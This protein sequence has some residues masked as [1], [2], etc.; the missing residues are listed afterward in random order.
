[1]STRPP[2]PP[3]CRRSSSGRA[4]WRSRAPRSSRCSIRPT[5]TCRSTCRS[6]RSTASASGGASRSSSTATP[7]AASRARSASSPIRRTSRPR[8]SR[9]GATAWARSTAPRCACWRTWSISSRARKA[10]CTA[11]HD[12]TARPREALRHPARARRHRSRARA[13]RDRG[14]RRARRRREDDALARAGRAPRGRGRRGDRPRP[15]SARRRDGAQDAQRLRPPGLQPPP[16]SHGGGEPA[17]HGAHPPRGRGGVP[18][19]RRRAARAHRARPLRRAAHRRALGRHE[20]EARDRQRAPPA[21]GAPPARRADGGRRRDVAR[22]DLGAPRT[23]AGSRAPAR[24]SGGPRRRR[25]QL[26]RG[27]AARHGVDA[28]RALRGGVMA[29]PIIKTRAL[30]KRF[31]AFTAVDAL[32]IEVAAG[33]I[34]AFLGANGSGKSTTIRMLIGLI[35]PT[36]GA[37]E[38]DGVDV[39]RHPRRVRDRIGYMGQKVSLYEGLTLGENVEFYAGLYGLAGAELARRWG[40]LRARFALAEAEGER[41]EDLPAG[42]RQR[43]GLAVSIMHRPRLLFLDEPTAGV[44][45]RSRALF[46]ELIQEEA[47][48]GATIFVT[49]HFLEEADYCD[50]VCFIDAGRLI[51]DAPPEALRRRYSGG[52]RVEVALPPSAR[53]AAAALLGGEAT[54]TEAGL[55]LAGG[56]LDAPVLGALA[57]LVAAHPEARVSIE[58]PAMTDVFRRV[59]AE[60]GAAR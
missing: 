8:R 24:R 38:V 21:P 59:L 50:R 11:G 40:A 1:M 51:A 14:H 54:L 43:A 9:R 52:Y 57:R 3:R 16:R 5:S 7:A 10:T 44:D 6:P 39:I 35:R 12:P 18:R 22:R 32:S 19:A 56:P 27:D 34:F 45:V 58:Q 37:I 15:R 20:A 28:A 4:S 53:A 42:I 60:A 55:A 47:E 25:G 29:G 17:L 41:P 48:A 33:S 13:A 30:T 49:T 46:W 31:G 26:H 36:A 23:R 2:S